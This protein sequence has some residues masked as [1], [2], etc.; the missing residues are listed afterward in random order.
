MAQKNIYYTNLY[1]Y[2]REIVC[3]TF[4]LSEKIFQFFFL[5]IEKKRKEKIHLPV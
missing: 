4:T 3:N 5:H 1:N 2:Y